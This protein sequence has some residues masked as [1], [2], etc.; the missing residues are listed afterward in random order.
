MVVWLTWVR[1]R[2]TFGLTSKYEY[3]ETVFFAERPDTIWMPDKIYQVES[4]FCDLLEED[5][6]RPYVKASGDS[7]RG[8]IHPFKVL[9][10][11]LRDV[12]R[13]FEGNLCRKVGRNLYLL[14][15]SKENP[16]K[17]VVHKNLFPGVLN[18]KRPKRSSLH[19]IFK[20]RFRSS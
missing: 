11:S 4:R 19:R 1:W 18:L 15:Q 5:I 14:V 12:P 3:V 10:E 7:S 16:A 6:L 13:D 8:T 17:F 9:P 20:N 2:Y